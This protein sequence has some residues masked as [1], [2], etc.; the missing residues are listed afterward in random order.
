MSDF[1]LT[2]PSMP[3]QKKGGFLKR[4]LFKEDQQPKQHHAAPTPPSIKEEPVDLDEIKRKLGLDDELP[5]MK[6]EP[7]PAP[8]PAPKVHVKIDDWATEASA[9]AA[10]PEWSTP[11][12]KSDWDQPL[13]ITEDEIAAD[14]LQ[15]DE[16]AHEAHEAVE[17]HLAPIDKEQ[18]EIEK[19]IEFAA[20]R[21][22]LPEWKLQGREITPEQYFILKNGQPVKSLRELIDILDYVDDSTFQHHV[23]EYRNDFSNWVREVIDEPD[24]ADKISVAENKASMLRALITHEKSVAKQV[25]KDVAV[26]QKAVQKRQAVVKKLEGVEGRIEELRK[27]LENK[28]KELAGER[29]RNAK[30]IKDK[31][32]AEVK[33]RLASQKHAFINAKNEL[34]KA[35]KEYVAKTH[36]FDDH[37]KQLGER[38]K[39]IMLAEQK[40]KHEIEQAKEAAKSLAEQ[41]HEASKLLK[42]ADHLKKRWEEMKKLDAQ[43]KENL[44]QIS[45]R[46]IEI[47]R[48]EE[49]LRQREKKITS[50]L[51]KTHEENERLKV[52]KEEHAKRMADLKRLEAEAKKIVE[53]SEE[54]AKTALETERESR[55]R[56]K[57]EQR[58]LE[59]LRK[60]IDSTLAKILKNKQKVTSAVALR[61]Q[62]EESMNIAKQEVVQERQ[63]MEADGY[64][65]YMASKVE[66]TPI[67]QPDVSHTDDIYDVKKTQLPL[68]QKVEECRQALERRDLQ[69]AKRLYNELR[70]E[71]QKA[72]MEPV[73]KNAL[74]TNIREL[75]DDIHL[76]MLG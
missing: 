4:F 27:Q 34:M 21:P 26:L 49:T 69:T 44:E 2:P 73:E 71:F 51:T 72:K 50:D 63:Q 38:E 47:S 23:N 14:Q 15:D 67:G 54:R 40:A 46:E 57:A 1:D 18:Q 9:P 68:Y 52:A 60:Q 22:N 36:E 20:T 56:L 33:K 32:D 29:K 12:A 53:D 5:E 42:D 30:L 55:D 16:P 59:T 76:A 3:G 45:K 43:T 8:A 58:K 28:T 19:A 7:E 31:L 11:S 66:T 17:H 35:K 24:L 65:S 64:K 61:K 62:L 6:A 75:Y 13:S 70:V 37:V 41:K 25:E 48:R 39:K 74:Y 10:E